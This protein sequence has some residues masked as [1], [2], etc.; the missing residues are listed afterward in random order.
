MS[1]SS[2]EEDQD[3]IHDEFSFDPRVEKNIEM[4]RK[5]VAKAQE[6]PTVLKLDNGVIVHSHLEEKMHIYDQ[7][8]VLH[9]MCELK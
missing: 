9:L 8:Q 3:H 1:S 6:S 5:Q 7:Y 4:I 2:N